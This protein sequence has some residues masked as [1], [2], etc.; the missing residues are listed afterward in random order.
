MSAAR[1]VLSL[2]F[3]LASAPA[4]GQVEGA[5]VLSKDQGLVDRWVFGGDTIRL[6]ESLEV[7]PGQRFGAYLFMKGYE[8]ACSLEY[9]MRIVRPDGEAHFDEE[10]LPGASST[11]CTPTRSTSPST[12]ATA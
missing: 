11:T 9:S 2:F 6:S 1:T 10:G 4:W 8:R 12:A 5:L 7:L 3:A